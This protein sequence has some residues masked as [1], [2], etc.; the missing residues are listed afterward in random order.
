[1]ADTGAAGLMAMASAV[2]TLFALG[3]ML[4]RPAGVGVLAAGVEA[5]GPARLVRALFL[6]ARRA[7]FSAAVSAAVSA[8]GVSTTQPSSPKPGSAVHRLGL[9]EPELW[10]C[11]GLAAALVLGLD[12]WANLGMEFASTRRFLVDTCW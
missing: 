1:M 12:A 3:V 9:A 6:A 7:R 8:A 10:E 5:L 2:L 4:R 11:A